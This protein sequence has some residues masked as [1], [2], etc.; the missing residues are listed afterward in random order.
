[1]YSICYFLWNITLLVYT[2]FFSFFLKYIF[3]NKIYELKK[4]NSSLS[5]LLYTIYFGLLPANVLKKDHNFKQNYTNNKSMKTGLIMF[6]LKKAYNHP[7]FFGMVNIHNI[8]ADSKIKLSVS[9]KA[10]YKEF[11][12]YSGAH[13]FNLALRLKW[14]Y[15]NYLFTKVE[16][17]KVTG[18][19]V[20][21]M[22]KII[23]VNTKEDTTIDSLKGENINF[24][25]FII[26]TRIIYNNFFL[27]F[28]ELGFYS[29]KSKYS[30]KLNFILLLNIS[31]KYK[32]IKN[33]IR[34]NLNF[35]EDKLL[36]LE[37]KKVNNSEIKSVAF[38]H[39]KVINFLNLFRNLKIS[40]KLNIYVRW[41]LKGNNFFFKKII[42]IWTIKF[43]SSNL[44]KHINFNSLSRYAIYYLRKTKVFNKGRYSRNRQIYKTGVYWSLYLNIILM[45]GLFFWFYRFT[46]NFG[47]LWWF[48]FVFLTSFFI[49][50][51][52]KY[53]YYN[54]NKVIKSLIAGWYWLFSI[55]GYKLYWYTKIFLSSRLNFCD[56]L[57]LY[58]DFWLKAWTYFSG[59]AQ[60]YFYKVASKHFKFWTIKYKNTILYPN[61]VKKMVLC[62]RK[63]C[64][65]KKSCY[66]LDSIDLSC[67]AID[68]SNAS[69]FVG[70]ECCC[71]NCNY[72]GKVVEGSQRTA[73][74]VEKLLKKNSGISDYFIAELEKELEKEVFE[75]TFWRTETQRDQEELERAY[76][77]DDLD[78]SDDTEE[79][80]FPYLYKP[81]LYIP[82]FDTILKTLHPI[83]DCS[84]ECQCGLHCSSQP[85]LSYSYVTPWYSKRYTGLC[86]VSEYL[87]APSIK[88]FIVNHKSL[89]YT[90]M[91]T[92]DFRTE[93]MSKFAHHYFLLEGE[94]YTIYISPTEKP[95][96]RETTVIRAGVCAI[97]K[98]TE[99]VFIKYSSEAF[100]KLQ[101][102]NSKEYVHVSQE[103]FCEMAEATIC[104]AIVEPKFDLNGVN[105]S[106]IKLSAEFFAIK[107]AEREVERE[108]LELKGKILEKLKVD[109]S[110]SIEDILVGGRE[111]K[112]QV[113]EFKRV[114]FDKFKILDLKYTI[115]D[116]IKI[117]GVLNKDQ[118]K[119]ENNCNVADVLLFIEYEMEREISEIKY[120][121]FTDADILKIKNT[122]FDRVKAGNNCSVADI[123]LFAKRQIDNETLPIKSKILEKIMA[124]NDCNL[125]DMLLFAGREIE[126]EIS[127][128]KCT[129]FDKAKFGNNWSVA[130]ILL[131]N[132]RNNALSMA[133]LDEEFIVAFETKK[134]KKKKLKEYYRIYS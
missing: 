124:E 18:I 15:D 26:L 74:E 66:S 88:A 93:I 79:M 13:N 8:K 14:F 78:D 107:R 61:I 115:L 91:R 114:I 120:T 3:Y 72:A 17:I 56:K 2:F 36:F 84:E 128:H 123:L 118:V 98:S 75:E 109:D 58:I 95:S 65:R 90:H 125:I 60:L 94:R 100:E 80:E 49:P 116:E 53:K 70:N 131:L 99:N 96:Q 62:S 119:H 40:N 30:Y 29:K 89:C 28:K 34:L 4:T 121:M 16:E 103:E 85:Q 54:L 127:R 48:F 113:L 86:K 81:D 92:G 67:E 12:F 9:F 110:C 76:A 106:V 69:A 105:I 32:N 77:E 122:I 35:I 24:L 21:K 6:C 57:E 42:T 39:D 25:N 46:I 59:I 129:I 108:T 23:V 43:N 83:N 82:D 44:V 10:L 117:Y 51:I 19:N 97:I 27:I 11:V 63:N 7:F 73:I 52:I 45:V 20:E 64:L 87:F 31:K 71:A 41:I 132:A 112:E 50:K 22:E 111:I 38:I 47:Y 126:R 133:I 5:K 33:V 68:I 134:S 55:I 102:L 1:M 37:S 101:Y 130:D 104:E